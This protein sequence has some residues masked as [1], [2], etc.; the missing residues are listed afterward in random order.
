M[1]QKISVRLSPASAAYLATLRDQ[2]GASLSDVIRNLIEQVMAQ[3][4]HPAPADE[5]RRVHEVARYTASLVTGLVR[6]L[7]SADAAA[8]ITKAIADETTIPT[9]QPAARPTP[10]VDDED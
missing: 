7:A 5:L 1:D 10:I 8:L 3:E 6:K 2:H 4:G 9:S